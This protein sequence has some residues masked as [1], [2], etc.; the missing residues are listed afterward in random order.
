MKMK[1]RIEPRKNYNYSKFKI[2]VST[3]RN[4]QNIVLRNVITFLSIWLLMTVGNNPAFSQIIVP[5]QPGATNNYRI[6]DVYTLPGGAQRSVVLNPAGVDDL[7]RGGTDSFLA[8]LQAEFP[9]WTFNIAPSDLTGTFDIQNNYACGL[10][11][12]DCGTEQ[13]VPGTIIG[14][15]I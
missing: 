4:K 6:N 5:A 1:K 15:F 7:L 9:A 2:D 12:T 3:M 14:S 8:T 13:G 11:T 10:G